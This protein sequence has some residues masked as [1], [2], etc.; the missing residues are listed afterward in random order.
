MKFL[1]DEYK[2]ENMLVFPGRVTVPMLVSLSAVLHNC[3]G[4]RWYES[5]YFKCFNWILKRK[6]MHRDGLGAELFKDYPFH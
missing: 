5:V 3:Q 6:G 4:L 2:K 1:V